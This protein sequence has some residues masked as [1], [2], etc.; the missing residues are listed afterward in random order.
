MPSVLCLLNEI[1]DNILDSS[2]SDD[3]SIDADGDRHDDSS[4]SI[5]F[6]LPM[7]IREEHPKQMGY[8]NVISQ[9]SDRDFWRHFRVSRSTFEKIIDFLNSVQFRSRV[10]FH[11]GNYPLALEEMLLITLH[12]LGNQGAIRT[13]ADKFGRTESTVFNVV[14][15]V[16]QCLFNH[17]NRFIRW[18][19][20]QEIPAV[21]ENFKQK[22]GFPGVV[23]V[24]DG[25]HVRMHPKGAEQRPYRNY[26]KFQSIVLMGVVLPDKRFSYIITGFPGSNHDAYV[27]SRS[28]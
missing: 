7:L 28:G 12:Y 18:P 1:V 19:S 9:Y 8:L 20:A 3:D 4:N 27:F 2:S 26:K 17:Q 6:L 24:I 23:G 14:A 25:S 15:E 22:F 10:T 16:C 13:V 11:G 21:I 5:D